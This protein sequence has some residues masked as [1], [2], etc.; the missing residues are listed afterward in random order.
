[1]KLAAEHNSDRNEQTMCNLA[2]E[3]LSIAHIYI[4]VSL[5]GKHG[6]RVWGRGRGEANYR[7]ELQK[8]N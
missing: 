6:G 3:S 7:I 4:L 1:M 5:L 2:G 8:G